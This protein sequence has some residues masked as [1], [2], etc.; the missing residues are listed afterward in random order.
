MSLG[1][2]L[3]AMAM[4]ACS[5]IPGLFIKR[6]SL[7]GQRLAAFFMLAGSALGLAGAGAGLFAA[8]TL[9]Y[10]FPWP[11]MGNATIGLDPLS[12]FFLMP[13]FL[14]GGLGSLYGL[15]YWKQ[16]EHPHNARG[17]TLFWGLL[18]MGMSLLLIGRQAMSFLLGWEFMALSAFF[19]VATE[20]ENRECRKNALIYLLSTHVTT[21]TLFGFFALWHHATGSYDLVPILAGTVPS[22][23]RNALFFL[24]F[25]GFGLKAGM[26]PLHY[27]LPGAH[28][29]APSHVSAIL[30]GVMLKMGIY[31]LVRIGLLLPDPPALW[32]GLILAFGA[33]SGILGVLLAIAQH[34]LKRLLAY[35]SVENIGIILMGLGLAMLGRSYDKPAWVA[36]GLAGGLLHVWNHSLFK[37]LL[38]FGAGSILHATGKRNLDL[39]GGLARFMPR[40]ALFF[41][42]GAVAIS[43]IPPL[44]GF[45]SEWILYIGLMHPLA[46]GEPQAFGIALSVPALAMIGALAAACFVKVYASVFLGSPRTP[47]QGTVHES[48][49]VMLLPM[50]VLAIICAT[51]GILPQF[52]FPLLESVTGLSLLSDYVPFATL[53]AVSIGFL[54][55][56]AVL[57]AWILFRTRKH[58]R[59]G[60]WDCGYAMP[61]SRMQYTASSFG[62]GLVTLF[63]WFLRPQGHTS[64]IREIHPAHASASSHV[65]EVVLDRLLRPVFH[66]TERIFSWFNRFQQGISQ[67]YILYMLAA[68]LLMLSL[69]IPYGDWVLPMFTQ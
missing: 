65:D 45:V 30:S 16:S 29:S 50:A 22:G 37:P 25:F 40:T 48:P 2:I 12:A 49:R 27:W 52:V 44:N 23:M 21:L 5:G 32:G 57:A 42:V 54:A 24:A 55:S 69:L 14:I 63:S 28:A 39:M 13:V 26:M 60:T 51:I 41:L 59:A 10:F 62:N 6:S 56:L 47:E 20:D 58:T 64:A 34:D 53:S 8:P 33:A 68:V 1:L 15:G 11:A 61:T 38:F 31:G 18:V 66:K 46:I 9:L 7:W 35:H 67:N 19:L 17:L 36:L 3:S 4:I 43:G